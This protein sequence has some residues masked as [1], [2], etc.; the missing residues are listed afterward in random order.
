MMDAAQKALVPP[1]GLSTFADPAGSFTTAAAMVACVERVLRNKF[2][3]TWKGTK[4]AVFGATGVVGFASSII[5][6]LEGAQVT[7]VAHRGRASSA[8]SPRPRSRP[9]HSPSR[10]GARRAVVHGPD[11]L[12]FLRPAGI[13]RHLP[14][15]IYLL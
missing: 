10:A 1:F 5:A 4:V 9:R 7:L 8:K 14:A 2:N 13:V 11:G 12:D 6:A 3:K 15:V